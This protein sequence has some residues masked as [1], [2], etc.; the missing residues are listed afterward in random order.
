MVNG[1]PTKWGGLFYSQ[2]WRH[3]RNGRRR[4]LDRRR[5]VDRD[6][7]EMPMAKAMEIWLQQI[8]LNLPISYMV[9][10]NTS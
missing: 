1:V 10:K 2:K 4:V 6:Y 8:R 7:V 5:V 9:T 3:V